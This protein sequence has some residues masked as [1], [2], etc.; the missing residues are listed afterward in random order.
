MKVH[1]SHLHLIESKFIRKVY[2]IKKLI[3]TKNDWVGLVQKS[4]D[5]LKIGLSGDQIMK[6]SK[7]SFKALVSRAVENCAIKY[8]NRRAASPS[9]SENLIKASLEKEEYF[10]DHRFSRSE[11]ELLFALR[12]RTVQEIKVSFP[13]QYGNCLTC[14]LCQVAVCNLEHLLSCVRLKAHVNIPENVCYTHLFSNTDEQL[15][16]V[17][18]FKKLLRTRDRL[19]DH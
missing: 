16:V 13:T 12:T 19:L 1:I 7:D 2:D 14:D 3:Q 6:V 10:E 9:K 4:L 8:L 5:E 18:I 17:R 11:V 15:R